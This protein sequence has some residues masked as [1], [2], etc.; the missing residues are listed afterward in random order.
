M[1]R[2]ERFSFAAAPRTASTWFIQACDAA[3][4]VSKEG[5]VFSK[6]APDTDPGIY[7]VSMVRRPVDW[8]QSIYYSLSGGLIGELQ[9]D[10]IS[11]FAR[12]AINVEDFFEKY[13][14]SEHRVADAFN[15]Y[16]PNSVVRVEDL[17]WAA[18]ELFES[19]GASEEEGKAVA[20]LPK[21]NSTKLAG[22]PENKFPPLDRKLRR[23]VFEKE[24]DFCER[25]EYF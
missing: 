22:F 10:A 1:I 14:Q 9:F 13:L 19:F 11:M 3:G 12:N 5:N 24:R 4:F 23:R 8:L 20:E 2:Y 16:Q 15:V 21:V 25:C 6:H 17:P 18:V 7:K